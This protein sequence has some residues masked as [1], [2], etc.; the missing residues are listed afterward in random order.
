[1]NGS[2]GASASKSIPRG[3][4]VHLIESMA[5]SIYANSLEPIK[6]PGVKVTPKK[7]PTKRIQRE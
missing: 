6:H 2:R 1:M 4:M 5:P 7:D 3:S